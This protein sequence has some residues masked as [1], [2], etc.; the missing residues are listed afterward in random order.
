MFYESWNSTDVFLRGIPSLEVKSFLEPFYLSVQCWKLYLINYKWKQWHAFLI[1][2]TLESCKSRDHTAR[3]LRTPQPRRRQRL[4]LLSYA[5]VQRSFAIA[6][7]RMRGGGGRPRRRWGPF[8]ARAGGCRGSSCSAVAS[9]ESRRGSAGASQGGGCVGSRAFS[10]GFL[11][12]A[13]PAAML[14]IA[15]VAVL[16][17]LLLSV[18]LCEEHT[19]WPGLQIGSFSFIAIILLQIVLCGVNTAIPWIS[20]ASKYI[21][22]PGD[23]ISFNI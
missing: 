1:A 2:R 8:G 10:V 12:R 4:T 23:F 17:F 13:P 19:V 16:R 18:D 15:T 14:Y 3:T 20:I 9:A 6:P 21:W 11:P 7:L 22:V 5:A